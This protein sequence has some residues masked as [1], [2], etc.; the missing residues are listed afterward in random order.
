[1]ISGS[2]F[3]YLLNEITCAKGIIQCLVCKITQKISVV[4]QK[5]R[6]SERERRKERRKGRNKEGRIKGREG[7]SERGME[8]RNVRLKQIREWI[9][10]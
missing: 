1:M 3:L 10:G 2:Q 4:I 7:R 5:E 6:E 8:E 9:Q